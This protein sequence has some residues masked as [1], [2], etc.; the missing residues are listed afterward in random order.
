[1]S[2]YEPGTTGNY[3]W[4][5]LW[6]LIHAIIINYFNKY[7]GRANTWIVRVENHKY[8]EE[9]EQSLI[10]KAFVVGFVNSNLALFVASFI[11]RKFGAVVL[12]LSTIL[13]F[14]QIILNLIECLTP[15]C[16]RMKIKK[17]AADSLAEF[18]EY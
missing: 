1:M 4:G 7:Y 11:D 6:T 12:G 2:P 13:I 9:H 17:Q 15:V 10:V 5:Y 14:K 18:P 3:M 8:N 16:K